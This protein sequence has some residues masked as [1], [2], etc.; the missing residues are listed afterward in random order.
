MVDFVEVKADMLKQTLEQDA[1][2]KKC[3]K[4][5]HIMEAGEIECSRCSHISSAE[6]IA[7]HK[8]Q[9]NE[10]RKIKLL[11]YIFLLVFVIGVII[12]GLYII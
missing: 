12:T 6:L 10:E 11:G 3:Y 5:E 7:I 8:Q 4:C 9:A 2:R 1:F